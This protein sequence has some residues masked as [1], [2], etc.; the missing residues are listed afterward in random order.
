MARNLVSP[1]ISLREIDLSQVPQATALVGP[2]FVGTAQNGP[3]FE[4]IMINSYDNEYAPTFGGLNEDHYMPYAAKNYLAYGSNL[5]VVRVGGYS[6]SKA[7]KDEA[8]IIP[9]SAS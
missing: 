9:A 2:A 1:G 6:T 4:P 3:M 5:M 8:W 7:T